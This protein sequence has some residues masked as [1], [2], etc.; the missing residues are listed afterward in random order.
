MCVWHIQKYNLYGVA[1]AGVVVAI[2]M[3]VPVGG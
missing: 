2:L 3:K 1:G